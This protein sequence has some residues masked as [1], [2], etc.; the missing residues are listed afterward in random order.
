MGRQA[1]ARPIR[2]SASPSRSRQTSDLVSHRPM[3][4]PYPLARVLL[5]HP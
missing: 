2:R 5:V 1:G 3:E 4:V